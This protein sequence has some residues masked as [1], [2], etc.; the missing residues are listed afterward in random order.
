MNELNLPGDDS[1]LWIGAAV[2]IFL[3]WLLFFSKRKTYTSTDL[4]KILIKLGPAYQVI[5]S[6]SFIADDAMVRVD[7][8]IVSPFGVFIIKIFEPS[9][10]LKGR[11]S[12][13]EW[14]LKCGSRS[15]TIHNPLWIN[16]NQA[17]AL[18]K[19]LPGIKIIAFVVVLNAQ[20]RT[21][22]SEKLV[23]IEKFENVM[24]LNRRE[25]LNA[26]KQEEAIRIVSRDP[27]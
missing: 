16:R 15:E 23:A 3:F 25:V 1:S 21:E 20:I 5:K 27:G 24:T 26:Q 6:A 11:L 19:L 8:L 2:S 13:R 12:D 14:I 22:S 4:D 10:I 9:G 17:N 7:R 18:E